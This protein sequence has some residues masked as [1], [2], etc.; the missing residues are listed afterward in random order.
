MAVTAEKTHQQRRADR[1][2]A[3]YL[4]SPH[5]DTNRFGVSTDDILS[6]PDRWDRCA[7]AAE[8]GADG[9]THREYIDDMR[10]NFRAWLHDRNRGR[11]AE[12]PYRVEQICMVHF[13]EV[14]AWHEANGSL[15][16]E[17]G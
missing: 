5:W 4:N 9:S 15:D 17:I 16:Q 12:Y 2:V 7:T 1:I 3:H 8:S 10:E 14:E 6:D 13:D 11:R